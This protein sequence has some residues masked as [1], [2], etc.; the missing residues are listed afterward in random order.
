MNSVRM[1]EDGCDSEDAVFVIDFG[2]DSA[3]T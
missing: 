3:L 1:V 2:R